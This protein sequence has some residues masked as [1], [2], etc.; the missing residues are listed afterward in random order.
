[1]CYNQYVKSPHRMVSLAPQVDE[2]RPRVARVLDKRLGI[3][4]QNTFEFGLYDVS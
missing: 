3:Q 1:M 4:I 2:N